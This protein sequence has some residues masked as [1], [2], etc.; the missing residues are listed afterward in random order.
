MQGAHATR[1]YLAAVALTAAAFA[2]PVQAQQR[3]SLAERVERLEQQ[4]ARGS[5][6]DLV[7]RNQELQ[8]QVQSLLG[9]IEELKFQIGEMQRRS[10]DQYIDLDSRIGRLEGGAP[11][12]PAEAA[13]A[14][15]G[16]AL[17]D[18]QLGQATAASGSL[19]AEDAALVPPADAATTAS[20]VTADP[21]AEKR[22]YDDA[23]AALKDGRYAESARRFQ[24]FIA[25]YPDST[26]AG[27]AYYWLGE[28]YYVTQNYRVALDTFATLLTRFPTN[29]KAPD[30][31]L[32]TGYCQYELKQ[33]AEAEGTL[34][35]VVARYPDTTV[36]RLASGRLRAL[37]LENRR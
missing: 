9:Q 37:K 6:V 36:A 15:T 27:N 33:W 5:T 35:E 30:A 2:L 8:A 25:Q 3:L 1:A 26:L 28:S 7:N 22:S 12:A 17:Q 20:D 11:K 34:N 21:D 13:S 29:Q 18:I 24:A 23:F 10:R 31:L 32:K 19:T 4:S 16:P 14:T